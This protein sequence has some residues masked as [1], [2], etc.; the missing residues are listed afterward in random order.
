MY[1]HAHFLDVRDFR[2]VIRD[3]CD[4]CLVYLQFLALAY[5][6]PLSWLDMR[7]SS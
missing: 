1:Y 6:E 5:D 3:L 2:D 7:R 4:I